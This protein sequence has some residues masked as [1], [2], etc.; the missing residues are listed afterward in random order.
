MF[1]SRN[2]VWSGLVLMLIISLL[3]FGLLAC[4]SAVDTS[5]TTLVTTAAPVE[6]TSAVTTSAE[7]ATTAGE[8]AGF[9]V[10][11]K[12]D[13]G[14]DVVIP[15]VPQRIISTSIWSA[16]M[17]Y[18]LVD[19]S[20]IV[21]VSAWG[22]DPLISAA[23]EQA[24]AVPDRVTTGKP[25]EIIA[26]NPDLVIIDSFSDADGS[27]SK[28]LTDA[29]CAVLRMTSPTDFVQ[30]AEAITTLAAAAGSPAQGEQV[31]RDMQ[32]TLDQVTEKLSGLTD[33]Q[34]LS[35]LYYEASFDDAGML[36]AYGSGSPFDAI[37]KA[38]GL[39]NVCDAVNYTPISKEKIVAEWKPDILIVPSTIYDE[40]YVARNDT[41]KTLVQAVLQDE[42]MATV[43]AVQNQMIGSLTAYYGGSTSQYMALAVEELAR[44]AY[45]ERFK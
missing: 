16:E 33:D 1:S 18:E 28:T 36:S 40:N 15:E 14:E 43:P 11:V 22:D 20:R 9:P 10:T 37:A 7:S 39:V 35:V 3:S 17:L 44:F 12:N 2:K 29:G 26:L 41:E 27:L 42:L 6:T 34:R 31:I 38:A 23:A 21:A 45:P 24:Q 4:Q 8:T 5:E 30:I 25:E 19:L 13:A 32:N